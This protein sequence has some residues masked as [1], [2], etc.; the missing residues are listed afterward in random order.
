MITKN[1][2]NLIQWNRWE[3]SIVCKNPETCS[4]RPCEEMITS[5]IQR[6]KPRIRLY[7]DMFRYLKN[8]T[9][10]YF[11]I[12]CSFLKYF[13]PYLSFNKN[14]KHVNN[15]KTEKIGVIANSG[16]TVV[17]IILTFLLVQLYK[18]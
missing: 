7:I 4:P 9:K 17:P 18:Q 8:C 16:I 1:Y 13:L 11:R 6:R 5:F 14:N 12:V 2:L 10:F 15:T 3:R